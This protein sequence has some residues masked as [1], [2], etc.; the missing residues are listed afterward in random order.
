MVCTLAARLPAQTD[1]APVYYQSLT[2]VKVS[3]GKG[4]EYLNLIRETGMKVAQVR[5]NAGE[6]VS[7]T[8]L[9]PVFPAGQDARAD[10]IYSEITEGMPRQPSSI[11]EAFKR[12]NITLPASEF[13]ARRSSLSSLVATELFRV[14]VRVGAVQ[15]GHYLFINQM[16]VH[17]EPGFTRFEAEIQKPI[18]EERV[19]RGEMSGW[20]YATRVLPAGTDIA[21]RA[22]TADMFPTW[23]AAFRRMSSPTEI[24][25]KV[26]PGKN[27][28][29]VMSNLPKLR[30]H[31]RR[32]LW[33]VVERVERQ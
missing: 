24:F 28:G 30:D 6:I 11:A 25:E 31:A 23:E 26:H 13:V 16:K 22:H 12:A 9:R 15:K 1:N 33:T 18:F 20:L 21:Y 8:V 2:H 7:W 14:R 5:A 29:E 10:Y 19:R 32:E 27:Y 17:D 4:E 3:P